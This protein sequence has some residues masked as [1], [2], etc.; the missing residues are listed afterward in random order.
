MPLISF[1]G[2]PLREAVTRVAGCEVEVL[3]RPMLGGRTVRCHGMV[4]DE[5]RRGGLG[6]LRIT[7]ECSSAAAP[8]LL[9][10]RREPF[11]LDGKRWADVTLTFCGSPPL[12]PRAAPI[13]GQ[14]SSRVISLVIVSNFKPNTTHLSGRIEGAAEGALCLGY[15]DA[16]CAPVAVAP[17][18][19]ELMNE[20][21]SK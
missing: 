2:M 17:E 14:V 6:A 19:V 4:L 16:G 18:Q 8:V 3:E 5:D 15:L 12:I 7:R 9:S 11:R 20:E 10:M 1:G 21:V 13:Y